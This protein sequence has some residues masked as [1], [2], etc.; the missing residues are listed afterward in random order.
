LF[1]V[2]QLHS[3]PESIPTDYASEISRWGFFVC[4]IILIA[5][6]A[7]LPLRADLDWTRH[8]RDLALVAEQDNA[9]RN[10]SY[11]G[12]IAAIDHGNPDTLQLLAHSNLG[13][14][15]A[16]RD[17]LVTPGVRTDPMIFELLEPIPKPRPEFAP[18]YSRLE[19]LVMVPKTR[20]WVLAGG[21]LLVLIGLLPAA[22]PK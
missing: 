20:L 14:I 19:K 12:M 17:A 1:H 15:P 4:G 2:E 22:K 9:A 5:A 13:M 18:R 10:E 21:I 11:K 16:N 8:Q 7:I 3:H 6:A